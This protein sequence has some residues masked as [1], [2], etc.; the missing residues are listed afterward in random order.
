AATMSLPSW[1]R[2]NSPSVTALAAPPPSVWRLCRPRAPSPSGMARYFTGLGFSGQSR[3]QES[4][5]LLR[6]IRDRQC[7][8]L[9]PRQEHHQEF[10]PFPDV[11]EARPGQR[12]RA[13]LGRDRHILVPK[14]EFGSRRSHR[15]EQA[16]SVDEMRPPDEQEVQGRE[17]YC[18]YV[19]GEHP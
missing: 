12:R 10:R 1:A 19:D 8:E 16:D 3:A 17:R 2:T 18:G 14:D 15:P 11:D 13:E 9:T 6:E 7:D 4:Q 5:S